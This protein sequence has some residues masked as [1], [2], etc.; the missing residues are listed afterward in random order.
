MG[1]GCPSRPPTPRRS[2][3][4]DHL[5]RQALGTWSLI[6]DKGVELLVHL[7]RRCRRVSTLFLERR[8]PQYPDIQ[9]AMKPARGSISAPWRGSIWILRCYTGLETRDDVLRLHPILPPELG[10]VQFQ[11]TFRGHG[12]LTKLTPSSLTLRLQTRAARRSGFTSTTRR[13]QCTL[14]TPTGSICVST[15]VA[16]NR[17]SA[18]LGE[19]RQSWPNGPSRSQKGSL[20][21]PALEPRLR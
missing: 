12:I 16:R 7:V 8:S 9:R 11:L 18:D 10:R 14:G 5:P 15:V 4:A 13:S 6:I 19:L 20:G 3:A 1:P 2:D 21:P 17:H